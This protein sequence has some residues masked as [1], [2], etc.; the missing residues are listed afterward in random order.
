MLGEVDLFDHRVVALL[1][2][3]Y[4]QLWD[5]ATDVLD[6]QPR[7]ELLHLSRFPCRPVA[8]DEGLELGEPVELSPGTRDD[9]P[10]LGVGERR[11]QQC[12]REQGYHAHR[13]CLL[14][15]GVDSFKLT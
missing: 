4:V 9:L 11:H 12:R 13:S 7:E 3:E 1:I 6:G 8:L 15:P 10:A 5:M 14:I 2:R